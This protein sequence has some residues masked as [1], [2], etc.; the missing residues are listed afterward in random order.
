LL[1]HWL[2]QSFLKTKATEVE[3]QMTKVHFSKLTTKITFLAPTMIVAA[4]EQDT[5][6]PI[7][8]ASSTLDV[9][10]KPEH[11]PAFSFELF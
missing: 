1:L 11:Q 8:C 7:N 9:E 10:S 5:T 3:A 2:L 4:Q 6:C